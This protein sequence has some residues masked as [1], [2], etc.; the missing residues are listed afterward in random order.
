MKQNSKSQAVHSSNTF[1]GG[2]TVKPDCSRHT[3]EVA[4]IT[5]M[6]LLAEKIGD[7]HYKTLSTLLY[8]LSDKLYADG[9]KDFNAGRTNLSNKLFEAQMSIQRSHQHIEQAWKVS[10]PFMPRNEGK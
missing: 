7:L 9:L 6:K 4:G 8:H 5:D 3:K 1:V 2:S 10:Q